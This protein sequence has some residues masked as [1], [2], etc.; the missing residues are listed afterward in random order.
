MKG[1]TLFILI[2]IAVLVSS[3]SQLYAENNGSSW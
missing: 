2:T 3:S 1:K